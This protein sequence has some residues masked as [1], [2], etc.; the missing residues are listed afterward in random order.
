M[1]D[2]KKPTNKRIWETAIDEPSNL[3]MVS[4]PAKR[5]IASTI[6][7]IYFRFLFFIIILIIHYYARL[8]ETYEQK[9]NST[10]LKNL[11]IKL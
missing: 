11:L 4:L 2:P 1:T 9:K 7:K 8:N 10:I 3:F 5:A 6:E